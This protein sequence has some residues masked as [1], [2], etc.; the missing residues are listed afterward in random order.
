MNSD[1]RTRASRGAG[2]ALFVLAGIVVGAGGTWLALRATAPRSADPTPSANANASKPLYQCPMHPTITSDHPGE[3]PICGMNMVKVTGAARDSAQV[4]KPLGH[5]ILFYRSPMNPDQTSPTPR[6]DEMGMDFIPV[7]ADEAAGGGPSVPGLATV[8]I[9]PARQQLIG[10]RTAAVTAG[11]VAGSWRTTGRVQVDPT[12]VRKTNVKVSGYIDRLYVDFVGRPVR[13]GQPLFSLYSPELLAAENEYVL[14]LQ[15]RDALQQ[16][17]AADASG[18]TLVD[19]SRRK[20]ELWDV[21]KGEIERLEQ[22]RQ[23]S[24]T[25]TFVSPVSG[26]VTAKN[27][28]QGASITAGDA[29]Y[30]IT[31]LGEVWVMAD[32]YEGDLG[33]VRVGMPAVLTTQAYPD[34]TFRGTVSF[35]DPILDPASRTAKV[36]MH[37]PNP[38]SVLKPEMY[39]DVMLEGHDRE[40]LRIPADAVVR[41]GTRDVVFVALGE[42][43]FAPREVRLGTKTGNDVEILSGLKLGEQVV[44]RANFLI[45]SESQL[46]ASLNAL[47]EKHP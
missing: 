17:G 15:T 38:G 21:P 41:A 5:Q 36:H 22:T 43:K 16:A 25:L 29:P 12:R 11:S 1:I 27:V 24:R 23:P 14:A 33:R 28:V 34:R 3:C 8:T 39:G 31:D 46:R 37:F 13:E 47:T 35:V 19:A 2:I 44:T 6:K 18:S 9:D 40:G 4:G 26:V 42:G 7:Y 30:E 20:L 10:L 45:D 32:A